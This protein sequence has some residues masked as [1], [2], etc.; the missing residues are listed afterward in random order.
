MP[1]EPIIP[2][3][4]RFRRVTRD[5]FDRTRKGR[6]PLPDDAYAG[7]TPVLVRKGDIGEWVHIL[8]PDGL[9]D[10]APELDED[11]TAR[12]LCDVDDWF[13]MA[14]W[15]RPRDPIFDDDLKKLLE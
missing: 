3:P 10:G 5:E 9:L 12:T 15:S 11:T 13:W 6:S 2:D 8:V 14:V 4:Y 7:R 1:F